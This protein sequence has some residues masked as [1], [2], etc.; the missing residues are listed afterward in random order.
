VILIWSLKNG[1]DGEKT[2]YG[3]GLDLFRKRKGNQ[4]PV[5]FNEDSMENRAFSLCRLQRKLRKKFPHGR[6][7]GII[8][9]NLMFALRHMICFLLEHVFHL[10]PWKERS[11]L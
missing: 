7:P 11:R 9:E 5:V 2:G 10:N 8:N 3:P 6:R 1:A 4:T